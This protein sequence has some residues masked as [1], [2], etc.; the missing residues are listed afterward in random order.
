MVKDIENLDGI[1]L[2]LRNEHDLMH[3]FKIEL[4]TPFPVRTHIKTLRWAELTWELRLKY[5]WYFNYRAAL[6]QVQYPKH[7][8]HISWGNEPA[9]GKTL[10]YIIDCKVRAKRGKLTEMKRKLS[11]METNWNELFPINQY[12]AY[13]FFINKIEGLTEELRL[14]NYKNLTN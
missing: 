1:L 10:Q 2:P 6:L 4:Y 9:T 5:D 7:V 12:P 8:V 11:Y 13:L 3:W 14:L